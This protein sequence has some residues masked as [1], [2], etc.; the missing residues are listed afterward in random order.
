MLTVYSHNIKEKVISGV[1]V[2]LSFEFQSMMKKIFMF[3]CI[4]KALKG[5]GDL[6]NNFSVNMIISNPFYCGTKTYLFLFKMFFTG[7]E[8]HI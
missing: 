5:G 3:Y 7:Q 4:L 6:E 1:V 8:W 2:G